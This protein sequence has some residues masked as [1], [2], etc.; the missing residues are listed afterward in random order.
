M[1]GPLRALATSYSNDDVTLWPL[2]VLRDGGEDGTPLDEEYGDAVVTGR[3]VEPVDAEDMDGGAGRGWSSRSR[4][5]G[6]DDNLVVA[7]VGVGV[8][9]GTSWPC[10]G[11]D[12]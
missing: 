9:L 7:A 8:V 4:A 5:G 1:L 10:R 6:R 3:I 2:C 12:S 11:T